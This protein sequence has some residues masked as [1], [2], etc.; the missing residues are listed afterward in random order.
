[1]HNRA[2]VTAAALVA[3]IFA[4]ACSSEN[5]V[6]P[7]A[8]AAPTRAASSLLPIEVLGSNHVPPGQACKAAGYHAFDFWIGNWDVRGPAGGLAGTNVVKSRLDGCVVEENWTSAGI[9]FGRSLNTYDAASKTWSQ[10]WVASSGCG[11]G[12]IIIEGTAEN[13][14][15]TMRG[16]KEQPN[17][18]LVGPP[19]AP[20][21]TVNAFAMNNLI[22][23]TLLPS[24]SVLQQFTST[25]N[26][27]PL[28]EPA[29]GSGLR[30]D[31]VA[32]VTPLNPP[33]PSFCPFFQEMS[34]FDFML[35]SW[36][37]HEGNGNGTQGTAT[38]T[39][40]LHGCLVEEFVNGPG[41]YEGVSFN[42]FD[43]FTD[44]WS[45]TYI[46]TDGVRLLMYGTLVNGSIVLTGKKQGAEASMVR[47]SWIPDG[48]NRVV[49][50]WEISRNDGADWSNAKELV[51]TR[52]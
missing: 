11:N 6:S 42:A 45:R 17:G 20:P 39:K 1:M 13:G 19:C 38:F 37:I 30:Y 49:Q 15:M 22:R 31:R 28:P 40:G 21:P 4:V 51:Y 8:V 18:F 32:S 35:G 14:V 16:R 43:S 46:D 26:D 12:V 27:T 23:W 36:N 25:I 34:Q 5:A 33:D 9:G 48:A 2:K 10:M 3:A 41:G 29:P 7:G 24:G 50:R 47:V 44:K 52:Q